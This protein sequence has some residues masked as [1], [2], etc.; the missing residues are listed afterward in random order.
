MQTSPILNPATISPNATSSSKQADNSAKEMPFNQVL[1]REM[2]SRRPTADTQKTAAREAERKQSANTPASDTANANSPNETNNTDSG[3][4]GGVTAT[5][6]PVAEAKDK[7][8]H[9]P[10]Q[11]NSDAATVPADMLALVSSLAPLAVPQAQA[12]SA[13]VN[14][15][16]AL[17][18]IDTGSTKTVSSGAQATSFL[19]GSASTGLPAA[20]AATKDTLPQTAADSVARF[21]Q[22]LD[23]QDSL[24]RQGEPGNAKAEEFAT[25]NAPST[26]T[27]SATDALARTSETSAL[28][29][30]T[31]LPIAAAD[32]AAKAAEASS[33]IAPTAMQPLQQTALTTLQA[34]GGHPVDR[35]TPHVGSP[36]WD[37]ALGQKVVWMVAGEQQSA[38]LTLN[39]PDLGPLQ[40]V[41]NVSNSQANATF[42][43]AQPEVRQALE[44]AMP[45]LRDM[46][47]DAGIQLG[48]ANVST[49]TP[50]QQGAFS[51]HPARTAHSAGQIDGGK[52]PLLR[53]GR[54]QPAAGGQGLVDTFA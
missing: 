52:E 53:N 6:K 24:K 39:P 49:G 35:L 13:T 2:T 1:S 4:P 3:S 37:Q 22:L 44:A 34:A 40:I 29:T 27:I 19:N 32:I 41:L 9:D 16:S 28:S 17:P 33:T 38:S 25:R 11:E 30:Q 14:A 18:G 43:A 5:A 42:I 26:S 8:E 7:K 10:A 45:K 51:D 15:E 21:P 48:Q 20:D 23:K 54:I 46:L 47:S 36:A 50:N 31:A 12:G